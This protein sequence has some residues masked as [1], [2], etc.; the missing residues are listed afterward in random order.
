VGRGEGGLI[1]APT[2]TGVEDPPEVSEDVRRARRRARLTSLGLASSPMG[3]LLLFFL[4][5]VILAACYSVGALTLLPQDHYLSLQP[6]R[7]FL[8]GSIYLGV[9][10]RSV[11]MALIVSVGSVLLAYPIAYVL[12]LVAGRRKYTLLLVII[13]PFLT[14]YLLRVLALRVILQQQGVVNSFLRS[15][16]VLAADES[17]KWLFNSRFAVYFV[18]I[19]VWVPFVAL[20]IFVA[21]ENLDDALLEASSDLG[22]GRWRTFMTVT[23]PLSMPGVIGAFIFVFIPTIGEY[24]TPLLV[25]GPDNFMFGNAIQG[26]FLAGFDWQFGAAMSMFLVFAVGVLIAA[27][28]RYL[29]VRVVAE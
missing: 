6:W 7:D 12:A 1:E 14:S 20:P 10:W 23:L 5:P 17:V 21:L 4:I 18:L 24:V 16:H 8:F 13:A 22:A 25:G 26:A 11:Q 19:Y 27:F 28:G 9:F 29:N 2:V 3:Y 15:I